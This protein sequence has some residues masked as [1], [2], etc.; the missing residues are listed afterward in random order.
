MLESHEEAIDLILD[1]I[2]AAGYEPGRDISISLDS[3][4][5][6][7]YKDGAYHM[8]GKILS[9]QDMVHYYSD[10]VSKYPIYSIE[11]GLMKMILRAGKV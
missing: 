8:Q 10:L 2:K 6:E 3:A 7:F 4:S 9:S 5:S 11:D 1:A